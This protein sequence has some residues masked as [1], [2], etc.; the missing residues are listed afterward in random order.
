MQLYL[1]HNSKLHVHVSVLMDYQQA[2]CKCYKGSE[3]VNTV[4]VHFYSCWGLLFLLYFYVMQYVVL[5]QHKYKIKYLTA[6]G[7][8]S[9]FAVKMQH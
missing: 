1:F 4:C 5:A 8:L 2:L 6:D 9:N 3:T 7:S